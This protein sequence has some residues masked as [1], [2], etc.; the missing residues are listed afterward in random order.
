[1][2]YS[3]ILNRISIKCAL[4][5]SIIRVMPKS[6]INRITLPGFERIP[7]YKVLG[8]LI[9]EIRSPIMILR[10]KA[11]AYS[12]F[13][14]LFPTMIFLFSLL[15][16]V[17]IPGIT[18]DVIGYLKNVMP[19]TQMVEVFVPLINDILVKPKVGLLSIGFVLII[20]FMKNGV[21]TMMQSFNIHFNIM[22]GRLFL[23]N[24]IFSI[25]ITFIILFLFIV[26]IILVVLGKALMNVV[27]DFFDYDGESL[28]ILINILRYAITI[29][30]NFVVIAIL[31]YLG[32]AVRPSRFKIFTPGSILATTMILVVSYIFANFISNFGNY[33]K[34]Y[35]SMG[36]I[37]LTLLWLYWNA[38]GILIGFELNRSI[39]LLRPN[40][41]KSNYRK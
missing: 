35:G 18:N 20:F 7:I 19:N 32:P 27:F 17:P 16:Y 2:G 36:T 22:S 26:T 5:L 10:A 24:Q 39:D 15:A 4:Y 31:Y 38:M 9:K 40:K 29:T 41:T 34:L 33:N 13:M 14:A 37:I 11:I 3:W 25:I 1:M 21:V 8:L 23:K 30:L 6:I 12:Y 28:V